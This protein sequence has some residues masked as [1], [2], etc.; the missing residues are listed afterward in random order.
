MYETVG[1]ELCISR[2]DCPR[3]ED[4]YIVMEQ[5]GKSTENRLRFDLYQNKFAFHPVLTFCV[6]GS[7]THSVRNI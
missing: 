5:D 7:R 2:A 3:L 6:S 1:I 4:N